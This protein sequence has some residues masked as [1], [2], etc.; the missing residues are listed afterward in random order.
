M[1]TK[2][3]ATPALLVV[4]ILGLSSFLEKPKSE[5]FVVDTKASVLNWKG[6]KVTGEHTGTVQLLSGTLTTEGNVLNKGKF[7]IDLNAITVT[8][9]TDKSAN[10]KLVNHLKGDDFFSV[11]KFPQANFIT[12]SIVSKPGNEYVINGKLTIKGIT[13][14]IQFPAHVV[15]EGKR[16]TATAKISVDRTK[17]DIRFRSPNFFENLGD[18]AI[19]DEIEFN[20][21]LVANAQ[22]AL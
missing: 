16:I 9:I 1:K 22:A 11:A 18:K 15:R 19:Y 8:D 7:E 2:V 12:T 20:L 13:N 6:K 3:I 14:D 4:A 21:K 10:D 17:Y 5:N